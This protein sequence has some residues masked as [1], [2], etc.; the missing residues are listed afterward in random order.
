MAFR[1]TKDYDI[2]CDDAS[3][4]VSVSDF[5]KRCRELYDDICGGEHV[6]QGEAHVTYPKEIIEICKSVNL[7]IFFVVVIFLVLQH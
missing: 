6:S 2:Q 7:C 1:P 5:K 3:D 4:P